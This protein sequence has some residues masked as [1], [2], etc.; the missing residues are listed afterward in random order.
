VDAHE[1]LDFRVRVPLFSVYLV[2]AYVKVMVRK[3]LT[4]FTDKFVEKLVR[5]LP[6]RV[7]YGI[8]NSPPALNLVRPRSTRKFGIPD[9]PGSAVSWHIKFGYNSHTA[10]ARVVDEIANLRF[11]EILSVRTHFD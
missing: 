11:R 2:A 5:L 8:E 3:K 4:H 7:H 1:F 10:I 9:K 6:R